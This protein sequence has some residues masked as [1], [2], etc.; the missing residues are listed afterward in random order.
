MMGDFVAQR[1]AQEMERL[2]AMQT[3]GQIER[4][5]LQR[6]LDLGYTDFLRQQAYPKEQLAFYSSMLQG[7]PIAPGQISQSYGI[8]P[9][10]TQQLLGAGIAG[11]GLYNALGGFGG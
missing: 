4:E 8:T 11:V 1:Q 3:A 5:L 2:R 9:S 6:G 7:L 10:T